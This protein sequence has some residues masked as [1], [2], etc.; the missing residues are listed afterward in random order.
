MSRLIDV[1]FYGLFMDETLLAGKGV[2]PTRVRRGWVD[3]YDLRIGQRATL[4]P[5]E[6]GSA[7][8]MVMSLSHRDIDA[9]YADPSVQAYRPE[10]VI[11]RVAQGETIP[12][13]CFNLVDAPDESE[14]N[15]EYA[16]KLRAVAERLQL[17][18]DYV[19]AIR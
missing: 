8:G 2:Q 14:R 1:F 11:V 4:V 6:N 5:N 13:L 3:G 19:D 18:V 15:P 12:A 16:A 17:P 10:A 7:H 9:L